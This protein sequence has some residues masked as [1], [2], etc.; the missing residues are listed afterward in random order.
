M[1]VTNMPITRMKIRLLAQ[2]VGVKVWPSCLPVPLMILALSFFLPNTAFSGERKYLYKERHIPLELSRISQIS[3]EN[4]RHVL[5]VFDRPFDGIESVAWE[6]HELEEAEKFTKMVQ[7]RKIKAVIVL[8]NKPSDV[9]PDRVDPCVDAC[10]VTG[11][12]FS[13]E[14][15]GKGSALSK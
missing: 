11:L 5:I 14:E 13:A 10:K 1:L 6:V 3:W 15:K 12:V 7:E 2:D 9:N 8:V 4:R